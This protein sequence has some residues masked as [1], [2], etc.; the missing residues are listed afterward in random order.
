MKSRRT[1]LV[2]VEVPVLSFSAFVDLFLMRATRNRVNLLVC[3]ISL[4]LQIDLFLK[5]LKR[6]EIMM[7]A[8][9]YTVAVLYLM[10]PVARLDTTDQVT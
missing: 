10:K 3:I 2:N 7:R 9:T 4:H 1:K 8:A 6:F 5:L